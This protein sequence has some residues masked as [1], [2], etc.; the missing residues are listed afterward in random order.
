M[1]SLSTVAA[2][3]AFIKYGGAGNA[4]TAGVIASLV[5]AVWLTALC[6]LYQDESQRATA[7]T[8]TVA[9]A[10]TAVGLVIAALISPWKEDTGFGDLTKAF[11]GFATGYVGAK[12]DD[13]S[14]KLLSPEF[15]LD[16]VRGFRILVFVVALAFAGVATYSSRVYT[17][18]AAIALVGSNTQAVDG[19]ER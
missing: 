11:G 3:L 9:L 15:A 7:I 16:P 1:V 17:T 10:G 19:G 4:Q 18:H 2:V 5:G 14:K 8:L 12:A 13:L 6:L